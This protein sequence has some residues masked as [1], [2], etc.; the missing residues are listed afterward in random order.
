M[1]LQPNPLPTL[2]HPER[3]LVYQVNDPRK[4]FDQSLHFAYVIGETEDCWRVHTL[5]RWTHRRW[6]DLDQPMILPK[7]CWKEVNAPET[8]AHVSL[9]YKASPVE[10]AVYVAALERLHEQ[11]E[12]VVCLTTNS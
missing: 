9:P 1:I 11:K 7:D 12:P 10:L 8:L 5:W 2:L 6:T 3:I 4:C